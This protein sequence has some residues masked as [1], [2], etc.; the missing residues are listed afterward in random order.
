LKENE[1]PSKETQYILGKHLPHQNSQIKKDII[2]GKKVSYLEQIWGNGSMC[3]LNGNERSSVI[4]F[5]CSKNEKIHSVTETN[6]CEYNVVVHTP[7]LCSAFADHE[8]LKDPTIICKSTD[9]IQ[10][11]LN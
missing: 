10:G 7:R 4:E 11:L 5:Y 9:E 2:N 3:N 1:K 6:T 8:D